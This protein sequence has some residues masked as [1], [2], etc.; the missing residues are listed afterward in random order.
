MI[1]KEYRCMF[2]LLVLLVSSIGT[3]FAAEG[4]GGLKLT[5]STFTEGAS[6]SDMDAWKPLAGLVIVVLLFLY[7]LSI[8]VGCIASGV[9]INFASLGKSNDLRSEGQKGILHV[10]LGLFCVC[11]AFLGIFVLW[12]SYGPGTW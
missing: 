10:L 6:W 4:G 1:K 3:A 7:G 11:V 8:F 12:N 5:T 9:K 2:L